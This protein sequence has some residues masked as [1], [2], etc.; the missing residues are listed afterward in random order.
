M[1][2]AVTVFL[3]IWQFDWLLRFLMSRAVMNANSVVFD[4]V[5]A[6]AI[7][8]QLLHN[9]SGVRYGAVGVTAKLHDGRVVEVSYSRTEHTRDL[10]S[11]TEK[12]K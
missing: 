3:G 5:K 2:N 11:K 10:E 7:V 9:A 6:E 1:L 12:N 8:N 4:N